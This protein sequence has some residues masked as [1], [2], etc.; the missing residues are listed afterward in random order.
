MT[1]ILYWTQAFLPSIG[2]VQILAGKLLPALRE[3]GFEFTVVT[4]HDF[5]DLPDVSSWNGIP[6]HR[7]PFREALGGRDPML[8][9]E[10]RKRVEHLKREAE[11]DLIHVNL[12]DPS[13][14]FHLK[15]TPPDPPPF[16]L[17]TRMAMTQA[18]AGPDT[19]LGQAF[20]A[21]DRITTISRAMLDNLLALAPEIRDKSSV[22]YN[23][24]E[25]PAVEGIPLQPAPLPMDPPHLLCLGRMAEEKGFDV[26]LRA[27]P[28]ILG[29]FPGCPNDH[30]RGRARPGFP[31]DASPKPSG[32]VNASPLQDGW[33]RAGSPP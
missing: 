1:R 12:T 15:T 7:F 21:A 23:G 13:V 22:V 3:R 11:P 18:S 33:T 30:G 19:V 27:L 10:T 28:S 31:E 26:A 5:T 2:G 32:S 16:L 9:L 17:T 25:P 4:S 24:L 29:A 20:H 8:L 14:F 6:V